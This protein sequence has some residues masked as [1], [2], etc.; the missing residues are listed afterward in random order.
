[1]LILLC[2]LSQDSEDHQDGMA[3]LAR[4]ASRAP[5]ALRAGRDL[6]VVRGRMAKTV[7]LGLLVQ[8]LSALFCFLSLCL[9]LC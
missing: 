6:V 7:H 1:M 2:H 5:W 3:H 8:A 4:E 9:C